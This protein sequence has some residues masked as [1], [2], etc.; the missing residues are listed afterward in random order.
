MIA[1]GM[2]LHALLK[3]QLRR[4]S[5]MFATSA[6][7]TRFSPDPSDAWASRASAT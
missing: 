6:G 4:T 5:A 7:A 1:K 2:P 3:R